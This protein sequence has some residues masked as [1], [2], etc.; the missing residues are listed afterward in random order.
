MCSS[1]Q[2]NIGAAAQALSQQM[3]SQ[4]GA[5]ATASLQAA[6]SVRGPSVQFGG[7]SPGSPAEEADEDG[8]ADDEAGGHLVSHQ[9]ERLHDLVRPSCAHCHLR[10][11]FQLESVE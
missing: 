1:G 11:M 5:S 8:A 10:E 3:L 4:Q 2:E 9:E 7:G 6:H